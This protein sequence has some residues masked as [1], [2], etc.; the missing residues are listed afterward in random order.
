MINGMIVASSAFREHFIN[1]KWRKEIKPVRM[2]NC[3]YD[4]YCPVENYEI[5]DASIPLH[6]RPRNYARFLETGFELEEIRKHSD[7]PSPIP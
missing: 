2:T 7:I 3:Q 4:R 6:N 5:K 1:I